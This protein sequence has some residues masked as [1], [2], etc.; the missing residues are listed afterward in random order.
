MGCSQSKASTDQVVERVSVET[1][2]AEAPVPESIKATEPEPVVE[3]PP[4][5]ELPPAPASVPVEEAPKTA[6]SVVE[7]PAEAEES[8]KTEPGEQVVA[9]A[10]EAI[11]EDAP[12]TEEKV[13][14]AEPDEIP[15]KTEPEA[16]ESEP[17][18]EEEAPKSEPVVEAPVEEETPVEAPVEEAIPVEEVTPVEEPKSEVIAA[19]ISEVKPTTEGTLTFKAEDVAFNEK[20]V[21]YYNFDGSDSSNPAN[22][23]H[24]SKR[25]SEFKALHA[26]LTQQLADNQDEKSLDL[27]ALPKAS[28]LQGRKNKK[29]LDDR[30][31]Q[32][33][34]LLNAIAA[35][36]VA[37]QSDVFKSFLA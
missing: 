35:H 26:Q 29:M 37:S 32:F 6:E 31:T 11:V 7:E 24:V 23:V 8:P 28:I 19:P 18:V 27:P 20:G 10:E 22:D 25:Y 9:T 15:V 30:K 2:A 1:P 34:A 13:S 36:S 21:A 14:E 17:V 33:T 5:D 16:P 12:K 4:A 3:A